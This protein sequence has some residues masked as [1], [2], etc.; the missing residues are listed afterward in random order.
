MLPSTTNRFRMSCV[1]PN[2]LVTDVFGS[3]PIR[4]VPISWMDQPSV[5]TLRRTTMSVAPA[6]RSIS[7]A[8]SAM[9]AAIFFSLSPKV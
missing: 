1:W 4:A 5:R 7:S 8:V 9:S 6:A 3:S 2:E